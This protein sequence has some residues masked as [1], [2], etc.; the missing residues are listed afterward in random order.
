MW[1]RF[2]AAHAVRLLVIVLAA[3]LF[4]ATLVRLAPAF[5]ISEAELDPRRNRESV[6]ALRREHFASPGILKFYA[7][8]LIGVANGDLGYSVSL[9]R[10]VAELLRERMIVS[11]RSLFAG[12]LLAI[13]AGLSLA[14]GAVR[15]HFPL[16]RVLPVAASGILIAIPSGA[17][18]LLFLVAGWPGT[19][20][21]AALLFPRVYKYSFA[22]LSRWSNSPHVIGA[23]ARGVSPARI[24]A[25][26]VIRPAAPQLLAVFGMAVS[27]GFPALVPIEAV[28][29]SPGILQLAWRAALARDLPILVSLTMVAAV[30]ISIGNAAADLSAEALRRE[31]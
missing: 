22:A 9:N 19:L 21:L 13:I 30:V 7:G 16:A 5:G 18:A 26:H 8:Y 17:L 2:V 23:V 12:V 6:E 27:I 10:P 14:V 29:D 24:L 1:V 28:C 31:A 20:A 4:G 25:R 11:L 3:G 15:F